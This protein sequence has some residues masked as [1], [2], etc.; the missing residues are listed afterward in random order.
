MVMPFSLARRFRSSYSLSSTVCMNFAKFFNS[1]ML[2][3]GS[4]LWNGKRSTRQLYDSPGTVFW[5]GGDGV[6]SCWHGAQH[7]EDALDPI[8][9]RPDVLRY[10]SG[11]YALKTCVCSKT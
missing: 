10:E 6:R 4:L 11:S 2:K 1:L 5:V 8:D 3:P 7:E 9:S